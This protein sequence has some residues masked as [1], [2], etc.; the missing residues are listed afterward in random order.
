MRRSWLAIALVLLV[1]G[2]VAAYALRPSVRVVSAVAPSVTTECAATT[3]ADA[4]ACQ[5]W[6]DAIIGAGPPSSTFE[7]DDLGRLTIDR[8]LLGF[9]SSCRISYF[10]TRYPD[11]AVWSEDAPCEVPA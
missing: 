2:A 5:A 9:A 1:A 6:G 8:P 4:I 3:G 11:D 10:T 7:M